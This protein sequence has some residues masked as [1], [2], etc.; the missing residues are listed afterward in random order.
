MKKFKVTVCRIAYAF[1]DIEVEAK[2][3]KEARIIAWD[4]SGDHN[5]SEK[6]VE[7]EP[8]HVEEI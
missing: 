2:D 3:E 5:Y 4:E 1:A 8:Q 7:Y 6:T